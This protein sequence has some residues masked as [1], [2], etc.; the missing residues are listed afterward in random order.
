MPT[1]LR[2]V[3]RRHPRREIRSWNG[4]WL[5]ALLLCLFTDGS[6]K[7]QLSAQLKDKKNVVKFSHNN[8]S[9][10]DAPIQQALARGD[11]LVT[12]ARSM[13]GVRFSDDKS[14]LRVNESTKVI[15]TTGTHQRDVEVPEKN[16]SVY[17]NYGGPGRLRGTQALCAVRGTEVE[18]MVLGDRDV[19]RCFGPSGHQVLVTGKENTLIT[20]HVTNPGAATLTSDDLLGSPEN[21]IGGKFEFVTGPDRRETRTVT[22]FDPGTGRVTLNAPVTNANNAASWFYIINPPNAR[23]VTLEKNMETHVPHV[24]GGSPVDP[25]PTEPKEFAGGDALGFMSDSLHGNQQSHLTGFFHDRTRQANYEIDNARDASQ[26]YRGL[27]PNIQ[28]FSPQSPNVTSPSTGGGLSVGV[29]NGTG[30]GSGNL[31]LGIGNG[32]SGGNGGLQLNIGGGSGR[33][34]FPQ[35][36]QIGGFG[37]STTGSDTVL[38]YANESAVLGSVF[39]RVG[40]RFASLDRHRDNQLDE[41]LLRYR[42]SHI[43]DIQIGRFHWLPGPVSNGQLGR[44]VDFTTCDGLLWDVPGLGSTGLQLAWF[45]KINPIIGP[46]A[47]GFASRF[48]LPVRTGQLALTA[49]ATS[50]K[51]VGTTADIVYPIIPQR[52]EV[53]GEGGVDTAHQT[54][55]AAGIYFPQLF[56]NFRADLAMELS[57]RGHFGHSV[58]IALHLPVGRHLGTLITISKPGAANW[59]PGFG[60]QARY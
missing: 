38:A 9:F 30:Q 22:N 27:A 7:A 35:R 33:A 15:I 42:D 31:G 1:V 13:A 41:M 12:G 49:L 32:T 51:T 2:A 5:V 14:Y 52:L 54:V 37:F 34:L 17:G 48:T 23:V 28:I 24:I 46:R 21:Y 3:V 19:V 36:P 10:Q 58:D 26:I 59:Q 60:I 47:G 45:D 6:A 4:I 25:Y 29:G 8:V 53:Y 20:G 50:Q 39:M 18:M 44:L 16:G 57:Y 43:G 11:Y 55:Y 40:G 56:H